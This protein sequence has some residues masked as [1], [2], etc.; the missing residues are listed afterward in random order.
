LRSGVPDIEAPNDIGIAATLYKAADKFDIKYIIEGH[1]FRTEGISPLGW[2]YMDG[3]YIAGIHKKYGR[4]KM[5]T[6]P[7]LP[8][9]SF[10]NWMIVKGIKK[11]RPMYYIDY[12]KEAAKKMLAI[13]RTDSAPSTTRT[14]CRFASASTSD[15]T[16]TLPWCARDR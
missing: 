3:R 12:K 6:F 8:L 15:P 16:A 2:L 11:V 4:R 9:S 1:S 13:S 10:M 7:N 14:F 5:K